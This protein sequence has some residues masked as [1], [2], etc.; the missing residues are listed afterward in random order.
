MERDGLIVA[1]KGTGMI[2]A[3]RSRA[4][5]QNG[6]EESVRSALREL[7]ATARRAEL[8]REV[9]DKLYREAWARKSPEGSG[10]T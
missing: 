10:N 2:V 1:R 7:V 6:V 8:G 4:A 5:A 3:P 9:V